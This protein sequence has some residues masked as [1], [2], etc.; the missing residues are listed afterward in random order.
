MSLGFTPGFKKRCSWQGRTH[1]LHVLGNTV[2]QTPADE[3]ISV[4]KTSQII[5]HTH[6]KVKK[7]E[8]RTSIKNVSKIYLIH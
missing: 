8:S 4:E 6:Q 1:K 5:E 7:H 3:S 2:E